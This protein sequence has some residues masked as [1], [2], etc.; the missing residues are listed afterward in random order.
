M[1]EQVTTMLGKYKENQNENKKIDK[2]TTKQNDKNNKVIEL[3]KYCYMYEYHIIVLEYSCMIKLLIKSNTT[4]ETL[5]KCL[6]RRIAL[7]NTPVSELS[8]RC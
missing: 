7:Y 5:F 8:E 2:K 4:K 6:I 1:F 3:W